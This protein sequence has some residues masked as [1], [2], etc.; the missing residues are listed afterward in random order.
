[1]R[2]NYN[3]TVLQDAL[4]DARLTDEQERAFSNFIHKNDVLA[5]DAD[6][7]DCVTLIRDFFMGTYGSWRQ[8]IKS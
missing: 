6:Y 8:H 2:G 5:S 4:R 1:M 3:D 7:H